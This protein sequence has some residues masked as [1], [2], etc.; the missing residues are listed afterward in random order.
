MRTVTITLTSTDP[1]DDFR[2][3]L[4][5]IQERLADGISESSGKTGNTTFH[6]YVAPP[7]IPSIR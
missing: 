6:F 5:L 4:D 7:V 3:E 2:Y 1:E